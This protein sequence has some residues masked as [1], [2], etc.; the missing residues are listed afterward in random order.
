M[1]H[2]GGHKRDLAYTAPMAVDKRNFIIKSVISP[3]NVDDS[4]VF[5]AV[6]DFLVHN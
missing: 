6:Y 1:V 5:D 2:K 4:M 3:D